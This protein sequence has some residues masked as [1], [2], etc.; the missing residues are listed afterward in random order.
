MKEDPATHWLLDQPFT[1]T[2]GSRDD[3][4]IDQRARRAKKDRFIAHLSAAVCIFPQT[5]RALRHDPGVKAG[6]AA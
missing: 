1:G 3:L 6:I 2:L 4:L 5:P